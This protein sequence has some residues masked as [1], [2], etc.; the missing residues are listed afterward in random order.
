MT[1]L[2][3]LTVIPAGAGSGKTYTIQE[4]L[5]E[6]VS[7]GLVRP[8][9]IVAVTFT[10][11][12]ASELKER[13]RARLIGLGRLDDAIRLDQAYISTIHGFGSRLLA[14][15]AFEGGASPSPRLLNDDEQNVLVRQAISQTDKVAAITRD[16]ARYG[17]TYE[18]ASERSGEDVFRDEMLRLV[19]LLRA[20]GWDG[21]D[22]AYA[23]KA[24]NWIREKY[25]MT[26]NATRMNMALQAAVEALLGAFPDSLADMF[27]ANKSATSEL[28]RDFRNLHDA[29]SADR[30]G[31]DWKLWA[32]LGELR[33]SRRG[34]ALP[35][36]YDALAEAVRGAAAE[37]PMHPGPLESA[38]EQVIALINA[39]QDV[40]V[41]YAASK[42]EAG[43]VDYTDMVALANELLAKRADVL[44]SLLGRVDCLVVDE[45]QDT[46]PLQFA[47]VWHLKQAGV[48]TMVVG[49]LKQAIM[50]FQGADPRLFRALQ[51][52]N[53][54]NLAPLKSNWRS[55][56]EI[57]K[58]V[59]AVGAELFPGAYTALE[60]QVSASPLAPLEV[61]HLTTRPKRDAHFVKGLALGTRLKFLLSDP[62]QVVFDR[63]LKQQR[64][65]RGS[66]IA[67]LCPTG[68][69]LAGYARAL[70]SLG[71]QVQLDE[72]GWIESRAVQIALHAL[73][74]VAN[75]GDRHAALYLEV[76][77]LGT[78][79]LEEALRT[80]VDGTRLESALLTRLDVLAA[81]TTERTVYTLISET[82]ATLE[83]FDIVQVWPAGRQERANL[84]R[85]LAEAGEFM[86]A[87][88]E[89]L[90]YGGYHG[91]GLQ[92]FLAWLNNK[93]GRDDTM[94]TPS[95]LDEHAIEL[96]T[97]HSSKG[98][99]WPVVTVCGLD[100]TISASLPRVGLGYPDFNDLADLLHKAEIEYSPKFAA[101]PVNERF[102][103]PLQKEAGV[104]A[105]RVLYV[106]IT[107]A[108][109]KLILEWPEYL[110]GGE[111][112]SY[113]S[114][115]AREVGL[116]LTPAALTLNDS[117][118]PCVVSA[119]DSTDA[120][121]ADE[122]T[123]SDPLIAFGRRA[124]RR[125]P[126]RSSIT[127]DVVTASSLTGLQPD[128][129]L[130][131]TEAH[132][133]SPGLL[134]DAAAGGAALGTLLHR[135]FEILGAQPS[136]TD[137]TD[138][139][140]AAANLGAISEPVAA[141]VRAF[142]VWAGT[143]F[144]GA[145]ILREWPILALRNDGSVLSGTIDL[146]FR[147]GQDVWVLDHKSDQID[148]RAAAMQRYSNQL[149]AY[150]SALRMQGYVVCG[151]GINWI[152]SGEVDL[153]MTE[154]V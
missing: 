64:Q 154:S 18:Y 75:P 119:V 145:E 67:V 37:L 112:V 44:E 48:P 15:F 30:L 40:L 68:N 58:F 88:R 5:G 93:A 127:A 96:V 138:R 128:A 66:D 78:R 105:R 2:P 121:D 152:R 17:Y 29:K 81:G 95:V 21:P 86:D 74:Y 33:P 85:L 63:H 46:N 97:W 113:W 80:L 131:V 55:Q 109:E 153:A 19:G 49:D 90:A 117:S 20:M 61:M 35:D 69:M 110:A 92:T 47:L 144:D 118:F 14:E 23:A 60:P 106:A 57:M 89:A 116:E 10:E 139:L 27:P 114:I 115:L 56:P 101:K 22:P 107:R 50:G 143:H 87:Q 73:A 82:L 36:G 147:R 4:R 126:V 135:C 6:W 3:Q 24:A 140:L 54:E 120:E 103:E 130:R 28:R 122:P 102:L 12:A 141:H 124:I 99:E 150:A 94:P 8:E 38:E 137:V 142:E 151:V 9:C 25:G 98:R 53:L 146:L 76:T 91:A 65:I 111:P 16:L 70:R 123:I 129:A 72:E 136:A 62:S 13:I 34:T 84:L 51:D 42:R 59:N 149:H 45:F 7:A 108:R 31:E 104:E 11:A 148:D 43:L 83:L 125:E 134:L 1:A 79:S 100:K 32:E 26:G 132:S 77:E 71:L 41:R 52:Q 39:A 133:Y